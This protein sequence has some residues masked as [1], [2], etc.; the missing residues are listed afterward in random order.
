MRVCCAPPLRA[1]PAFFLFLCTFMQ[2]ITRVS[3]NVA[4]ID[5]TRESIQLIFIRLSDRICNRVCNAEWHILLNKTNSVEI[6]KNSV[7]IQLN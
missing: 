4:I 6:L 1:L 7:E 3:I 5:M 2:Y